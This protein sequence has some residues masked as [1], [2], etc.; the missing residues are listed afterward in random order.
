MGRILTVSDVEG[1]RHGNEGRISTR[2][3]DYGRITTCSQ[4]QHE[5]KIN[6]KSGRMARDLSAVVSV[7]FMAL[8]K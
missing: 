5:V 7:A 4:C 1:N 6:S 8:P 3:W 2:I